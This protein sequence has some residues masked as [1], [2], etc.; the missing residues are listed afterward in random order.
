MTWHSISKIRD[1]MSIVILKLVI[2]T[3]TIYLMFIQSWPEKYLKMLN[4]DIQKHTFM[5]YILLLMHDWKLLLVNNRHKKR[6]REENRGSRKS[7]KE[8]IENLQR[9]SMGRMEVMVQF[10]YFILRFF[11]LKITRKM[12]FHKHY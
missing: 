1:T 9:H 8:R 2:Y 5:F 4:F 10:Q 11:H 12:N 6:R 3:R 7:L